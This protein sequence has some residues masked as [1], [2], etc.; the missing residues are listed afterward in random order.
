M[1][2]SNKEYS[3][4]FNLG[5]VL[6]TG[7]DIDRYQKGNLR[8]QL[9]FVIGIVKT[10]KHDGDETSVALITYS[11]TPY[12]KYRFDNS[13]THS[14]L[15]AV[16]DNITTTGKGRNIGEALELARQ[17]LF[18]RSNGHGGNKAKDILVV[19]TD[20]GSEDDIAVPS[21]ALKENNVRIFSVGIGRYMRG[22][23]NEMASEPNSEHVFT[24]NHYD[25]L[26]PTMA[27]MKDAIV[28]G[29]KIVSN[30]HCIPFAEF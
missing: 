3:S 16:L 20:G 21:F 25:G 12:V 26:G 17:E 27:S 7:S 4:T 14:E 29:T 30:L 15:E 5:F 11:D 8:K 28:K 18:N 10:L 9:E 13:T 24:V 22:Q 6:N 23:L 19:L 2:F 1:F